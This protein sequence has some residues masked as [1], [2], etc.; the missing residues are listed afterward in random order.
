MAEA[1][2][3]SARVARQIF[4]RSMAPTRAMV[5]ATSRIADLMDDVYFTKGAKIYAKGETPT[6]IFFV[7]SGIVHLIENEDT[8]PWVMDA[9][10][11]IG[12]IDA[13]LERPRTRD[14]IAMTDVHLL[15]FRADDYLEML[16]DNFEQQTGVL[17]GLG[18]NTRELISALAPGG[19]FTEPDKAAYDSGLDM[20]PLNPI[21][22]L[23]A[24]K[25]VSAFSLASVQALSSLSQS[26]E[27]ILV[28]AGD[29]S[30]RPG[31]KKNGA[32]LI[33]AR[34]VV[35]LER[36]DPPLSARFG[37]RTIAGGFAWFNEDM[38][39][40]KFRA[41]TP[42]LLLRLRNEDLID[43]MEDHFDLSRS[44]MRFTA[45]ERERLMG[46]RLALKRS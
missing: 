39:G 41:L 35:E 9:R 46:L 30:F 45:L 15:R 32:L 43:V 28:P 29:L 31:G 38:I 11:V 6:D 26:V 12:I 44:L 18:R 3:T 24:L 14:A 2:T 27:D 4:M 25:S 40:M 37:P 22:R 34:G 13:N 21:E 1:A 19:G 10:S 5:N 16:E 8:A 20:R 42:A 33:I 7:V 23:L 36:E 17:D